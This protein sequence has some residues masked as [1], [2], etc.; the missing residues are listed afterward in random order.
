MWQAAGPRAAP[1]VR[2]TTAP[3]PHQP[4]E[5][6]RR[7]ALTGLAAG[8]GSLA[9]GGAPAAAVAESRPSGSAGPSAADPD[10]APGAM[11]LFADPGFTFAGLLALGGAGMRAS[12]VGEVLTAINAAGL[13]EQTFSARRAAS[14]PG[15]PRGSHADP[16]LPLP[17]RRPVRRPG[18]VPRPSAAPTRFFRPDGPGQ[19]QL[20]FV[21]EMPFTARWERGVGPIVDR[22][23]AREDVDD[24]FG[25]FGSRT[26]AGPEARGRCAHRSPLVLNRT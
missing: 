20:L 23:D 17:A 4:S 22:P 24:D 18:A 26:C 5:P 14:R 2:S 8:A 15:P 21:E 3:S 9:L 25:T 12:E 1:T 16:A 13:S 6:S 7:A 11:K 19:G 10:P